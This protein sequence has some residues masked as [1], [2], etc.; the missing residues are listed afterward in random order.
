MFKSYFILIIIINFSALYA[1]HHLVTGYVYDQDNSAQPLV[2]ASVYW[3]NTSTGTVTND[4]G[5]FSIKHKP[6]NTVLL[7][8]Y[9]GFDTLRIT[10]GLDKP[11]KVIL[12]S[13][14]AS[15]L[16]EVII[17]QKR[18]PCNVLFSAP[19]TL[20]LLAAMNC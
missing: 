16:K 15:K 2:G 13:S 6:E 9:L 18:N 11:I 17:S 8:S 20:R 12:A 19:E 7:I 3:E 5:Y 14:D 4:E 1:L 10:S